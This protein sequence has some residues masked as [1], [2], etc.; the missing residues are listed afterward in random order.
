MHSMNFQ[1][2]NND[3]TFE[4]FQ[5]VRDFLLYMSEVSS[6]KNEDWVKNDQNGYLEFLSRSPHLH[7]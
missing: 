3:L 2:T 6:L 4:Q 7:E 1:R 5:K